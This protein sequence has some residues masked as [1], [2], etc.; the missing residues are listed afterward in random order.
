MYRPSLGT[1]GETRRAA[2]EAETALVGRVRAWKRK[3][4]EPCALAPHVLVPQWIRT[5]NAPTSPLK[6][7]FTGLETKDGSAGSGE[8]PAAETGEAPKTTLPET[9]TPDP[10]AQPAS[11]SDAG[12]LSDELAAGDG[13]AAEPMEIDPSVPGT[14]KDP[15]PSGSG[16]EG[17]PSPTE[18]VAETTAPTDDIPAVD[19]SAGA[20]LESSEKD[21]NPAA[22][23]TKSEVQDNA[24]VEPNVGSEL[25]L[26]AGPADVQLTEFA[27][28]VSG[29]V[30][31]STENT[32]GPSSMDAQS[33]ANTDAA[34]K[35][36]GTDATN[37]APATVIKPG[38]PTDPTPSAA[39]PK[40]VDVPNS[41][42]QT[43][44]P[45]A[46]DRRASNG[47]KDPSGAPP[48]L[49]A[50]PSTD[51]ANSAVDPPTLPSASPNAIPTDQPA[52]SVAAS[53]E[54]ENAQAKPID[55]SSSCAAS[56]TAEATPQSAGVAPSGDPQEA[57]QSV[58]SASEKTPIADGD[59]VP[60]EPHALSE[61][62]LQDESDKL[63]SEA[64]ASSEPLV[65]GG[66]VN[67]TDAQAAEMLDTG[68]AEA[69]GTP[70][71]KN[72]QEGDA[73]PSDSAVP[74][75]TPSAAGSAPEQLPEQESGEV[76][77]S[78]GDPPAPVSTEDAQQP[79]VQPLDASAESI[80]NKSESATEPEANP[81][82]QQG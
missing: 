77:L 81:N 44:P 21:L 14:D 78:L 12:R 60:A 19:L 16:L 82:G 33:A 71:L 30:L 65:L 29:D 75:V 42:T 25:A 45:S 18:K 10:Q 76:G 20:P 55:A 80:E 27:T 56:A 52:A 62:A 57:L 50:S 17:S 37:T 73:P 47:E 1:R 48:L 22:A 59:K 34:A 7:L 64:P 41:I 63:K 54:K 24:Q 5:E 51:E 68:A 39:D 13:E 11:A 67:P 53:V 2:A 36:S 32:D 9:G 8:T 43:E 26:S 72:T 4:A 6:K 38:L 79:A 15:T 35:E 3:Q 46:D 61:T 69:S 49:E 70:S 23:A 58:G 40:P 28:E 74:S 66:A 31:M